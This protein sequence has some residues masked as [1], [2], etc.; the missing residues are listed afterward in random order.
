LRPLG[1]GWIAELDDGSEISATDAFLATGKHDLRGW[2][3]PSGWQ[4]DLIAFKLHWRLTAAQVA[5]L[6]SCVELFL[7]PS[8]YAGLS[9]VENGIANLC[10][11]VRRHHFAQLNNRW[12]L[13]LSALRTECLPLHHKLSG[14]EARSD[15]PLAIASIPYGFVQNR[16]D[17]PWRLGDQAAVI[18]SFTGDGI[19]IALHSASLAA[20]YYLA[21]R[22]NSHFQSDLAR[23]VLNQ[24]RRATLL[25]QILVRPEGQAITMAAAQMVPG[26]V[27]GI[28]Q[29]TRIASQRLVTTSLEPDGD[30][31]CAIDPEVPR[32]GSEC[33]AHELTRGAAG[34]SPAST[35]AFSRAPAI[36]SGLPGGTQSHR[37]SSE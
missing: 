20:E 24:V 7:F 14:A 27:R 5:V 37:F 29:W 22:V 26:L 25:S 11:V 13:L 21:G 18:P 23:G 28:A 17:G 36:A 33:E 35:R 4:N 10:L 2:K 34:A 16:S 3:R 9:L 31:S 15:R 1:G 19:S 6:G 30:M 32:G 8:G 12:D